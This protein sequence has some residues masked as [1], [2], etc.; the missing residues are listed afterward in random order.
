LETLLL[1]APSFVR[2]NGRAFDFLLWFIISRTSTAEGSISWRT[3]RFYPSLDCRRQPLARN[4]EQEGKVSVF[5]KIAKTYKENRQARF[6]PPRT[7]ASSRA[8]ESAG[9]GGWHWDGQDAAAPGERSRRGCRLSRW[10]ADRNRSLPTLI[11]TD[12]FDPAAFV[13]AFW[14]AVPY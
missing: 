10:A 1:R 12:T 9:L 4:I 5:E 2:A 11:E 7:A 3:I 13:E 14:Q 6:H 8:R